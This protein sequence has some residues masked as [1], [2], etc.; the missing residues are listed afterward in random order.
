MVGRVLGPAAPGLR[1][2]VTRARDIRWFTIVLL[3]I[4]I[5]LA[6]AG[7][8]LGGANSLSTDPDVALVAAAVTITV[9]LVLLVAIYR[10]RSPGALEFLGVLTGVLT[11]VEALF[12]QLN[13]AASV[14]ATATYEFIGIAV[15]AFAVPWRPKAHYLFLC[16]AI[17]IALAGLSAVPTVTE[18]GALTGALVF[19]AVVSVIG[20]P[21]TW[22]SRVAL[23]QRTMQTRQL[24]AQLV[25]LA[26]NDQTTGLASRSALNAQLARLTQRPSGRL[27]MAMIDIDDFKSIN[28]TLGHGAGDVVLQCVAG[29]VQLAIRSSDRAYRYGG[30]E[31]LVI[32]HR[33]DEAGLAVTAEHIRS[34]VEELQ[35]PN[36]AIARGFVT[37]SVGVTLVDLPADEAALSAA[38]NRADEALYVAK[39]SGKNRVETMPAQLLGAA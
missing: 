19:A 25:E 10:A 18:R 22:R 37:V 26:H 12:S 17:P 33:V 3:A 8:I 39:R 4:A 5:A 16:F 1:F 38:K 35:L 31:F 34:A 30:E 20:K 9:G 2:E 15:I 36:P 28:D 32:L 13:N 21:V 11:L 7:P 27:G 29:A 6:V 24:N 23:H 14:D